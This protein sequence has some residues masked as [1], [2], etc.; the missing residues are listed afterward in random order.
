MNLSVCTLLYYRNGGKFFLAG[1]MDK[2]I[3]MSPKRIRS[4]TVSTLDASVEL[5]GTPGEL[6][7]FDVCDVAN[8]ELSYGSQGWQQRHA[9][10]CRTVN[11]KITGSGTATLSALH[12]TCY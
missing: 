6:V 9:V 4:V 7:Q 11:C 3:P 12:S 1:E 5:V 8:S 2:A 10:R